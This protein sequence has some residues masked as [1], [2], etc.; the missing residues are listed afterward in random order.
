MR[1]AVCSAPVLEAF[2]E[3]RG[4]V[5][6][7]L[8]PQLVDLVDDHEQQLVVLVGRRCLAGQQ[9]GQAQVTAVGQRLS[10][11]CRWGVHATMMGDD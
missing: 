2:L 10:G 4:L 3:P 6:D 5:Q 7:L 1:R 11:R 9:V 8:E